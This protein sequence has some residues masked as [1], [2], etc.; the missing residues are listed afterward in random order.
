MQR[1]NSRWE[2]GKEG[3]FTLLPTY[4][5]FPTLDLALSLVWG[6]PRLG[7]PDGSWRGLEGE[8]GGR[9]KGC[10]QPLCPPPQFP[11]YPL[12]SQCW[13]PDLALVL[14][15]Y[16]FSFQIENVSLDQQPFLC[17]LV[18]VCHG[19]GEQA[20]SP[21]IKGQRFEWA[22]AKFHFPHHLGMFSSALLCK[23]LAG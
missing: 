12:R 20:G 22:K 15:F 19:G 14:K 16:I 8:I 11:C 4:P 1:R 6:E 9:E 3:S 18:C 13:A 17:G 2:E 23:D 7:L 10:L 5:S 21:L